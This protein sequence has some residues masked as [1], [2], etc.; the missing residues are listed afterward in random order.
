[1]SSMNIGG[2]IVGAIHTGYDR[3]AE[4][5]RQR[6]GSYLCDMG[7]IHR[8]NSNRAPEP[9][10]PYAHAVVVGE[11]VFLSGQN[12]RD[13]VSARLVEGGIQSQTERAIRNVEAVLLDLG[14]NLEEIV[15][16]TVY[17][18]DLADFAAMNEIYSAL[19]GLHLPARSTIEAPLPFGA[20]VALDAIAYRRNTRLHS[21]EAENEPVFHRPSCAR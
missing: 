8:F 18:H 6:P 13:P 2:C 19:F 12:G 21:R 10:G 16:T 20:L 7:K 5:Y 14:S 1:M 9:Y 4:K 11:W 15:R 3:L 17:M